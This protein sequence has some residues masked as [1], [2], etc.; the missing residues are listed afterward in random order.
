ME[1][2]LVNNSIRTKATS[3]YTRKAA[4]TSPLQQIDR[5]CVLYRGKKYSYFGGCDYF[6]LASHPKIIAAI[7]QSTARFG[8]NVAASR[9]TTGNHQLYE[10]LEQALAAFF[11]VESALLFSNGYLTNLAVAQGLAGNFSHVL[12]DERAHTSLQDAARLF[13]CSIL[14]FKHRDFDDA[15][16]ALQRCGRGAQPVFL[17]DGMFS[18]D[19]EL[20]PL[21]AYLDLLPAGGLMV[22]DDAHGAGTL[23][24][25]GKG[26]LEHLRVPRK[27]IVQTITLSKAFGVYGGAIL[28]R[29]A[30]CK[31]LLARSSIFVGNTPLPLPLA[32]AACQALKL[33]SKDKSFR[34]RLTENTNYVKAKLRDGAFRVADTPSPIVSLV[35]ENATETALIKSQLLRHG[36]FPSFISYPGGP[37]SG[38]FRFA[39]SSEHSKKQL[40]ALLEVLIAARP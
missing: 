28:G 20:A 32:Y 30:F 21:R 36:V 16:R 15:S 27:Q 39:L 35:P 34:Q 2:N 8:L 13:Q 17:T 37:V 29:Q 5:T 25:T 4:L 10:E 11:G 6:R 1:K 23:G 31:K 14:T 3:P 12:L 7:Q 40:D 33:L 38:Y 26:T 24:N 18:H 9:L 22:V 19:G